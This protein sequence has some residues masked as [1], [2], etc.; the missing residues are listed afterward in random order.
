[1]SF[2][3]LDRAML[4]A[5]GPLRSTCVEGILIVPQRPESGPPKRQWLETLHAMCPTFAMGNCFKYASL[6]REKLVEDP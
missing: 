1:M 4:Q 6:P 2:G 5:A 3:D